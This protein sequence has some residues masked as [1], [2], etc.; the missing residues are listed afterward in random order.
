[1]EEEK[2]SKIIDTF[3]R[4]HQ[5]QRKPFAPK[6]EGITQNDF[7]AASFNDVPEAE[8]GADRRHRRAPGDSDFGA[9][10]GGKYE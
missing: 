8:K 10:C 7:S 9:E 6:I 2:T 1:M 3:Q 5:S 4:F